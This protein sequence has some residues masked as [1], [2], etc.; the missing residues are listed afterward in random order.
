METVATSAAATAVPP[1]PSILK[2]L[3]LPALPAALVKL[4]IVVPCFN[5]EAV[6]S[7]TMAKLAVIREQLLNEGLIHPASQITFVDDGSTDRSWQMIELAARQAPYI[8][9]IKLSTNKG[10]QNALLAALFHVKG[11]AVIT[12]DADLQDDVAAIREMVIRHVAGAHIVYGVRSCRDTDSLLKRVTSENFY[13]IVRWMGVDIVFNQAEFRLLSRSAINGL[14]QYREVNLFLR[15]IVPM[16][17][18]RQEIV[19]Y[20]RGTRVAGVTKYS[21][22]KLVALAWEALSSFSAAPLRCIT[23]A[24]LALF[25]GSLLASGCLLAAVL[26]GGRQLPAWATTLLPLSLF[27]GLQVLSVGIVGEYIAK[28]YGE[29]KRRPRYIIEKSI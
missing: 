22:A 1:P 13:R 6:L 21:P 7:T 2:E 4:A 3:K 12:L 5:E 20:K 28:I 9:G 17:G 11:D 18:F 10:Q 23:L 27:T 25:V 14:R 15:G 19:Y 24:G 29:V 8:H 16:L 26:V